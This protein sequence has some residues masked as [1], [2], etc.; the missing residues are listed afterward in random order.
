MYSHTDSLGNI[1][2]NGNNMILLQSFMKNQEQ[3][4]AGNGYDPLAFSN[5]FIHSHNAF[6]V[7]RDS[8][9]YE[10]AKPIDNGYNFLTPDANE[11]Q[12]NNS[13]YLSFDNPIM[14]S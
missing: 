1:Y 14:V 8:L 3:F 12:F 4:E 13:I 5:G 11:I 9:V 7:E 6:D 10:W 2:P